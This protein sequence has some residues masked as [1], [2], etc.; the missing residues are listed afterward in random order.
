MSEESEVVSTGQEPAKGEEDASPAEPE[1][2]PERQYCLFRTG[3]QRFCLPVLDIEEVV[4]WPAVTPVPLAPAFLTGIFNLRGAV[5]PIVDIALGLG[6]RPD[7]K[8][9]QVVVAKQAG[10]DGRT[11]VL[12]GLAADEIFGTQATSEPLQEGE[13]PA[14]APHCCGLLRYAEETEVDG[15]NA[16]RQDR[17]AWALDL[18]RLMEALPIPAI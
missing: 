12:L 5:V 8:P 15:A 10:E 4:D 2:R 1:R 13:A 6:R 3:R 7:L 17:L 16:T 11:G 18:K 14:D 9:R